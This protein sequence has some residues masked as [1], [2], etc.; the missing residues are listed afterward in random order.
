MWLGGDPLRFYEVYVK[1]MSRAGALTKDSEEWYIVQDTIAK[2]KRVGQRHLFS[3]QSQGSKAYSSKD[4]LGIELPKFISRC[5][6]AE[7]SCLKFLTAMLEGQSPGLVDHMRQSVDSYIL[8]QNMDS[9]VGTPSVTVGWGHKTQESRDKQEAAVL[10]LTIL[11]TLAS[12]SSGD[13]GNK[14]TSVLE[15]W[16]DRISKRSGAA[17]HHHGNMLVASVEIV[18]RNGQVQQVRA[19]FPFWLYGLPQRR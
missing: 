19:A 13:Y 2:W 14:M 7:K 8:V 17:D 1:E 3:F 15:E 6:S 12:L 9:L 16:Q 4:I 10:H 5:L 11:S 18:G